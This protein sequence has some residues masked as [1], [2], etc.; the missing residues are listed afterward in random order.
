MWGAQV[1]NISLLADISGI[2]ALGVLVCI[3]VRLGRLHNSLQE[4]YTYMRAG[5]ASLRRS[6]TL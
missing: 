2:L 6:D 3:F 1:M 5:F 4:A